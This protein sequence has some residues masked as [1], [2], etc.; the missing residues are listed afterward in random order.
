MK[1]PHLKLLHNVCGWSRPRAWCML[2]WRDATCSTCTGAEPVPV[3]KGASVTHDTRPVEGREFVC[4]NCLLPD[5]DVSAAG[6]LWKRPAP[7]VAYHYRNGNRC[8][9]PS[10]G[11][12]ISNTAR[13]CREHMWFK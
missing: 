13:T 8:P 7:P 2:Y 3:C 4:F 10:R 12:L 1:C 11:A 9:H 6:C 5:C